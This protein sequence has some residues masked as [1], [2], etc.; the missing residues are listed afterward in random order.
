MKLPVSFPFA[1]MLCASADELPHHACWFYEPK[2][3]GFRALIFRDGKEII[4]QS[5]N[6]KRLERYF[7]ELKAELIAHLPSKVILDGEIVIADSKRLHFDSLMMRINPSVS[8][9][10]TMSEEI[11]ASFI[12]FD[13]LALAQKDLRSVRFEQRRKKLEQL[14]TSE[15][16]QVTPGTTEISVAK[17]WFQ[18]SRQFGFE[19]TIAKRL[20]L[21]YKSAS[22]AMLKI[23]KRKTIDCL[24]AGYSANRRAL[25]LAVPSKREIRIVGYALCGANHDA[26]LAKIFTSA[27]NKSTSGLWVPDGLRSWV[28]AEETN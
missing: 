28:K 9:I 8:R 21:P 23:R 26:S 4:I 14:H 6:N 24:I 25:L 10:K 16:F 1:P 27:K 7:P 3:D 20:D 15:L 2:W 12:A 18:K 13:I 5:R 11:P 17:K 22:R 19:G